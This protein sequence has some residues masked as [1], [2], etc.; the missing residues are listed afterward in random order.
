LWIAA[1]NRAGVYFGFGVLVAA[2][3]ARERHMAGRLA[4]QQSHLDELES[5]RAAGRE[6]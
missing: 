4:D 2:L 3:L 5:L 6:V 1:A